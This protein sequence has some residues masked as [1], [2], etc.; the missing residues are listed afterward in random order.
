MF[1][2]SFI[3]VLDPAAFLAVPRGYLE[4]GSSD[5]GKVIVYNEWRRFLREPLTGLFT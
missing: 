5:V 4:T 3:D 2:S 1:T